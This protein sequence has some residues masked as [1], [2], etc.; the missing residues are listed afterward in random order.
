[1]YFMAEGRKVVQKSFK[2]GKLVPSHRNHVIVL[3]WRKLSWKL[4]RMN[5]RGVN[6]QLWL[7]GWEQT[8][9][10]SYHDG[11][12]KKKRAVSRIVLR[13]MLTRLCSANSVC[14]L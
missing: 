6:D 4:E 10:N 14:P 5:I 11:R 2:E 12:N 3:L 8:E 7:N 13:K 9:Q 1:M